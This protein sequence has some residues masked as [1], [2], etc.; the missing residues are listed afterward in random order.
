MGIIYIDSNDAEKC[1]LVTG[2]IGLIL[3]NRRATRFLKDNMDYTL[4]C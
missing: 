2:D 4:V 3:A 1:L